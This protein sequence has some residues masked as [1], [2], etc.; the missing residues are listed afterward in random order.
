MSY[1]ADTGAAAAASNGHRGLSSSTTSSNNSSPGNYGG[2]VPKSNG[3]TNHQS[4]TSK[5]DKKEKPLSISADPYTFYLSNSALTPTGLTP[6]IPPSPAT[7][8]KGNTQIAA[9]SAKKLKEAVARQE[10]QEKEIARLKE[11]V[12]LLVKMDEQ[13]KSGMEQE[14][15]EKEGV[16]KELDELQIKY[17]KLEASYKKVLKQDAGNDWKEWSP[18]Q[19]LNW[20]LGLSGGKFGKY[21]SV[22]RANIETENIDGACLCS[23]D[24]GD[25]HRLGITDFKDKTELLAHIEALASPR[26]PSASLD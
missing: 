1:S 21:A 15:R 18:L 13:T 20:M 4:N 10:A 3:G 6:Q 16:R 14:R 12:A 19:V 22:L 5:E 9:N 25:V 7:P 8:A 17:L 26:P 24:K 11:Q 23:L 2:F